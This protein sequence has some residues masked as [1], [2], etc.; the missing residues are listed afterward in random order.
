MPNSNNRQA[1]SLI[2][3]LKLTKCSRMRGKKGELHP[4]PDDPPRRR[5]NKQRGHG[6]YD[7]DRPPI[8]GMVER[9][10]GQVRLRVVHN[11]DQNTLEAHVH[12]PCSSVHVEAD[13][14]L[15]R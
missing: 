13:D 9:E 1:H 10:S 15:Y 12:R 2:L 14:L 11:P 3:I 8:V 6:T 5:A 4:D 7:N